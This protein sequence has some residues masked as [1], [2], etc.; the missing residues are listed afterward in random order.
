MLSPAE[1][2]AVFFF[3]GAAA[4]SIGSSMAQSVI[5]VYRNIGLLT[6]D[7]RI[8]AL[9]L[10]RCESVFLWTAGAAALLLRL[11]LIFRYRFDSDEPQHMHVAWAWA[12]GMMQYRDVFDNHMPLFHILSAPL[13][14]VAGDDPNVLYLARLSVVPLFLASLLLVFVIAQRLFDRRIAAWATAL[15]ALLP[16]FFLGMLEYRTDDL[17]VVCWLACIAIFLADMEPPARAVVAGAFLGLAFA[18]SM[19]SIL[20]GIAIVVAVVVTREAAGHLIAFLA[21]ALSVPVAIAMF[22]ALNGAW[23]EFAY[24]VLWHNASAPFDHV[25]WRVLWVIPMAPLTVAIARRYA[26]AEGD[27]LVVRRRLF[28]FLL[29]AVYVLILSAFWP[30]LSAESYLPFY[31]LAVLLITP[32]I[33]RV[34]FVPVVAASLLILTTAVQARVWR[35]D[36]HDEIALIR[37]VLQITR[38]NDQVMDLKGESLF[39][40]RPYW[41]VLESITHRKLRHRALRDDIA[42]ALVRSGTAVLASIDLP[43]KTRAFVRHNYVPWG[44][45]WVAGQ[46]LPVIAVRGVNIPFR[47]AI[48]GRYVVADRTGLI[49]AAID[50]VPVREGVELNG[51]WHHLTVS[52]PVARPLIIWWGVTRS[53]NFFAF[54]REIE[55]IRRV[56]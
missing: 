35:D 52:H 34:R 37:Q 18:V 47:I 10:S 54:L 53:P 48:A 33:L 6:R 56:S 41:L 16:P 31:P 50:G 27:A 21:T 28:V 45:L 38:P 23:K 9:R 51:G 19:K 1:L 32:L 3:T 13:F 15:S 8:F 44:R 46:R 39:R 5:V 42:S 26:R 49:D 12:R 17:W 55:E 29:C 2:G 24:C 36:A 7:I 25:W 20:F 40:R 22:F 11:L 14:F 30:I 43:P 4:A